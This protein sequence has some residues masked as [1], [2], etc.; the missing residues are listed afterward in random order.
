MECCL[1]TGR[2]FTSLD[3]FGHGESSG[4]FPE[5]T[6]SQWTADVIDVMSHVCSGPQV[7]VGSSMGGWVMLRVA[8]IRPESVAGL[9][10]IA[11]APDF[12][13]DLM[14]ADLSE[15]DR[16][17]LVDSG[18]ITLP[19]EY[20]EEPYLISLR[21]IEDG[22]QNLVLRAP[23]DIKKP[24]HLIHGKKDADVPWQTALKLQE[25]LTA[26]NVLVTLVGDG[27]HRLSRKSDLILLEATVEHMLCRD[28]SGI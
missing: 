4:S 19:S 17:Q 21:L 28:A 24:I 11:A 3:M 1:K 7:L 14:W 9:I 18:S 16:Q 26:E 10:G 12:T 8:Q 25:V 6:I 20:G 5:G 23:L 15:N 2:A 22:R 27:D 13:E